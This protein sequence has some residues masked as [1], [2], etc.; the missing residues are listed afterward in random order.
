MRCIE[1]DIWD[2]TSGE[3]RGEPII[4]HGKAMC[5]D[6]LFKDCVEAIAD[7]AFVVSDYPVILSFENHCCKANQ[8]KMARMCIDTFGDLLL[9][10]PIDNHTVPFLL[11]LPPSRLTL[12]PLV[13]VGS[14]RPPAL[15]Q[16]APAQ[17]PH[18]E[19][20]PQARD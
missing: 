3:H 5:T 2:G 18:Q 7:T 20:A 17:D 16:P 11:L 9:G 10:A 12:L 8:L 14:R 4:T 1:L 13:A 15:P 6:I 19:Q